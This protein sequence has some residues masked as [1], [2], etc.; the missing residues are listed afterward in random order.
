[1]EIYGFD[2]TSV[3]QIGKPITCAGCVLHEGTLSLEHADPF[4]SFETFEA[5]I[6]QPHKADRKRKWTAARQA[7][8]AS[9]LTG[10]RSDA[11]GHFG[12]AVEFPDAWAEECRGDP[13][14]DLLDALLCAVQEAWAYS[15]AG[16]NFGIPRDCDPL[17]GWI[18]DP[19]LLAS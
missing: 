15:Q 11:R 1:M 3:P 10:L 8:C 7:A 14:G 4:A 2:F 5:F 17:G 6:G 13:S 9:V 18:V 19:Q 12:F 16:N